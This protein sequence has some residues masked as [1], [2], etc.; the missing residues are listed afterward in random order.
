L[1]HQRNLIG[2]GTGASFSGFE[3]IHLVWRWF[4]F[5]PERACVLVTLTPLNENYLQQ[6]RR[7]TS[8]Y[9]ITDN[10]I[11]TPCSYPDSKKWMVGQPA[12]RTVL[13]GE[14]TDYFAGEEWSG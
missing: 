10:P 6:L 13:K 11:G 7:G 2:V 1:F 14:E 4:V 5:R 8:V 3:A 9:A 12:E